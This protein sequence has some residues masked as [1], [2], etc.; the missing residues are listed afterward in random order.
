MNHLRK[1]SY[2]LPAI[3]LL[4]LFTPGVVFGAGFLAEAAWGIV[5]K[6]FGTFAGWSG[7]LLNYSIN[8]F[9]VGFGHSFKGNGVGSS[10]NILWQAVRDIFNLTFIFGLVYIG[11]K[12]ILDSDNSSTRRTLVTLIM[13]A[14]LVNF[15]L[16]ITKAVVDFSNILATQVVNNGFTVDAAT[17]NAAISD[18]FMDQ[19]G[20]T[21]IFELPE[22]PE[23]KVGN[24]PWGY[25]FGTM[26]ILIV[27]I[28]VF[29]AGAF[30]LLIRYAVLLLYMILS[31]LM[32]IGW[33]FP[34]LQSYTSKYWKGLLGRAFFA[35]IYLLLL[36]FSATILG[37]LY[38][39]NPGSPDFAALNS[40]GAKALSNYDS[41]WPPFILA[42]IFLIASVVIAQKLG[43][44]GAG[45]AIKAGHGF[46]KRTQTFIGNKT[47]GWTA[48][49]G[50][51]TVGRGADAITRSNRFK[52]MAGNSLAG[53]Q[54]FKAAQKVASSSFDARQV[55]GV[56][57]KLGI[58][59]GVAGGRKKIVD[60]RK[61]AD[62]QFAKDIHLNY[63]KNSPEYMAEV[64]KSEAK[65][66]KQAETDKKRQETVKST[67]D[68]DRDKSSEELG[69]EIK[70]LTEQIKKEIRANE[71]AKASG[72]RTT[73][74]Y[75][76]ENERISLLQTQ[77]DTKQYMNGHAGKRDELSVD[78]SKYYDEERQ[79]TNEEDKTAAR[80]KIQ[81]TLQTISKLDKEL[82]LQETRT[83]QKINELDNKVAAARTYAEAEVD[84]SAEIAY[85][86][87]IENSANFW[88]HAASLSTGGLLGSQV[89]AGA[90]AALFGAGAAAAGAGAG[91]GALLGVGALQAQADLANQSLQNML[92]KYGP[93]GSV[94]V[95]TKQIKRDFENLARAQE[96]ILGDQ[97][98]NKQ[99]S[100]PVDT[101]ESNE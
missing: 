48:K 76:E 61:K 49:A 67:I 11:F 25:I 1:Q 51:A 62:E 8:E 81:D 34:G 21:G 28:F 26:I 93:D 94:M 22:F 53:K 14:L 6:V 70:N 63:D 77:L 99:R 46:R 36:Y 60:D 71:T 78:V 41:T 92:K 7:M 50:R 52:T 32:F 80:Q 75:D 84:Y 59:T 39:S 24:E 45:A 82:D 35:P 85:M 74:E 43:A 57:K 17:G 100:E 3:A 86:K 29:A 47:V 37:T 89:G 66:K 44:D 68:S 18:T 20:I 15:S 38:R 9:V 95:K 12:M 65:I 5:T 87:Q 58:G 13:A 27:M 23:K 4:I 42:C 2:L 73:N 16:F 90:S 31:P 97:A 56:G 69:D 96:K 54:L 83:T 88:N 98:K 79:A 72:T 91:A 10:V 33:V 64:A 101:D 19:L 55:G 30:L 40:G